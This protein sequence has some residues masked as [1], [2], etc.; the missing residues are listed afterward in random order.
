MTP[1]WAAP[2]PLPVPAPIGL[3]RALLLLT[4]FLH[5]LPMNLVLG[6]SLIAAVARVYGRHGAHAHAAE[7]ARLWARALPVL[8][9]ATITLGVAA[10]LFLQVLYG[11]VFFASSI[12]MAWAWFAVI[13]LLILAYYGAYLLALTGDTPRTWPVIAAAVVAIL[14]ATVA[15]IYSNNMSLMIRPAELV[16]QYRA[17]ARG[18]HL[19]TGDPALLPRFLHMLVGAVAI[20]GLAVALA[21]LSLRARTPEFGDWAVRRGSL[22]FVAATAVNIPVGFWWLSALPRPAIERLVLGGDAVAGL[23]LGAGIAAGLLAV[24]LVLGGV[25]SPG[26]ARMVLG[27]TAAALASVACMVVTRDHVRRAALDAA[28]FTPAAWVVPPWGAIALFAVLLVVAAGLVVWM[29]RAVTRQT[30]GRV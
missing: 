24:A 10:L 11:R 4:F 26:P 14:V 22:W 20:S 16:A 12:V 9:A 6:G 3:L 23:V 17:D 18:M 30:P 28:G 29:V 13:P 8:F 25:A 19:A 7:L 27:G 5:V 15:F 21:G 2:D 1:G